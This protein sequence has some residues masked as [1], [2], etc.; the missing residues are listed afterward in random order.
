MRSRRWVVLALASL[1]SLVYPP[2]AVHAQFPLPTPKPQA[3]QAPV[4]PR[5][6]Q[7]KAALEKQGLK[8][9]YVTKVVED[10]DP[11]WLAQTA[12]RYAQPNWRDV[13]GQA[14]T[15]WG[16][17]WD[18][19]AKDPPQ[20]WFSGIQVWAKYGI[21]IH[22]RLQHLTEFAA[23]LSAA[24]SDA[25]KQAA[26]EKFAQKTIVRVFDY[27]RQVFVDG[28]DFISKNFTS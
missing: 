15:I 28:K 23:D 3:T 19:A 12:A 7:V 26:F 16:A 11:Q 10:K 24:K 25:E 1:A 6:D 21:A 27:E 20:T 4:D 14:F 17:M 13:N 8:V 18:V 22:V 9:F 2:P 5:A